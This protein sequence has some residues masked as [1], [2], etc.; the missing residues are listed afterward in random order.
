MTELSV[1][2]AGGEAARDGEPLDLPPHGAR[3]LLASACNDGT[4][5]LWSLDEESMPCVAV[6]QPCPS[7]D[8]VAVVGA[9]FRPLEPHAPLQLV[10]VSANGTRSA[11]EMRASGRPTGGASEASSG[12]CGRTPRGRWPTG[13]SRRETSR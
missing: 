4:V 12:R 6:L 1:S 2:A 3:G 13:K 5:R 10:S 9:S 8:K 7:Q 11:A